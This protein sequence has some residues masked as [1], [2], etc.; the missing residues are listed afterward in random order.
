MESSQLTKGQKKKLKSKQ[1]QQP[2]ATLDEETKAPVTGVPP[3]AVPT[4]PAPTQTAPKAPAKKGKGGKKISKIAKAAQEARKAAED[5]TERI[6]LAEIEETRRFEEERIRLEE[7]ERLKKEKA[8]QEKKDRLA[9]VNEQKRLGLWKSKAQLEEERRKEIAVAQFIASG[10]L[11]ALQGK[12]PADRPKQRPRHK[13]EVVQAPQETV[14][15]E[16]KE[17]EEIEDWESLIEE[18]QATA[19]EVKAVKRQ[20][21]TKVQE[22]FDTTRLK[23]AVLCILGHV[24]T[25]KTKLLDK[26]RHT[27]VQGGEAGGITQQIGATM[28]PTEAIESLTLR[29]HLEEDQA[30]DPKDIMLAKQNIRGLDQPIELP[31]ILIIDTPGHESFTNLRSRGSSLCNLAILVVD[32]MHGLEQQTIESLEMILKRKIPFV[33]ALNKI[34]RLHEWVPHPDASFRDSYSRQSEAAKN[35]FKRQFQSVT[36]EFAE[37]G[38]NAYLYYQNDSLYED[39]NMCPTS[40]IT[41][42]GIPD[43]LALLVHMAQN[44]LRDS[45]LPRPGLQATVLEV[46]NI[47]GLGT[48]IDVILASGELVEGDTIVIGGF[49]GPIVTKIR[50]LVTPQPLKEMRVKG[51]YVHHPRIRATIGVKICAPDLETA[52]AGTPLFVANTPE[53]VEA[54]SEE[55]AGDYASLFKY[56]NPTGEGVYVQA[57]TIGSLEALLQ[58][59]KDSKIPV[60]G[61]NIGTVFK[62]DVMKAQNQLEKEDSK[63]EFAVILAFDIKISPEASEYAEKIGVKIFSADIIYHLTI[64]FTQF[65]EEIREAEKRAKLQQSAVFPCVLKIVPGGVFNSKNPIILGVDVIGGILKIGT[66]IAVPEASNLVIG[67]VTSIESNHKNLTEARHSNGSVGIKITAS[68]HDQTHIMVG[69]HFEPTAQLASY[70]T[71]DSIDVLKEY[72]RD[73]MTTDDWKLVKTLKKAYGI[74]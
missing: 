36:L 2:T 52:M 38:L 5:E 43:L 30:L 41:G 8:D 66:P 6:R 26:I 70:L 59:L 60:S 47:E 56:V 49:G 50:A 33:I 55:V 72:F 4:L 62:K 10:Q 45:L 28:F 57:S 23:S 9:W 31:G 51:E 20:R 15:P 32:I 37:R 64:A 39:I 73:D 40:A 29:T 74:L 18:S 3:E 24:D 48:T 42:E 46:K 71:R 34:D 21:R 27:N 13:E 53:E 19:E 61:V 1:K 58:F 35:H 69:R 63:P 44:N 65:V 16:T 67:K 7:E 11:P 25:G 14:E 22:D 12:P 68:N 54:A 17:S